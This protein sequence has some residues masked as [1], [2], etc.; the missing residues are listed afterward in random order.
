MKHYLYYSYNTVPCLSTETSLISHDLTC[1]C[2]SYYKE[3]AE[4]IIM[5]WRERGLIIVFLLGVALILAGQALYMYAYATI[6]DLQTKLSTGGLSQA[7][8]WA[9]EGSLKWWQTELLTVYGP[10]SFY[11]LIAGVAAIIGVVILASWM[12]LRDSRAK[13]YQLG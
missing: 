3:I 6:S 10:L 2:D 5:L 11:V 4:I 12:V 13:Q 7:E 8:Y 9:A 1:F